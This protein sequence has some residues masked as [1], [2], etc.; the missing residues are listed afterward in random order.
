M[1]NDMTAKE[2]TEKA[3]EARARAME[4][5]PGLARDTMLRV[6]ASYD[7][8]AADAILVERAGAERKKPS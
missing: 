8:L 2:W 5:S 4:M 6:A 7:R 1:P 3:E